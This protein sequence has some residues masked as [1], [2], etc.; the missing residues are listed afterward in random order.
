MRDLVGWISSVI[1]LVTLCKQIHKQWTL[2]TSE[3]VSKWF[4]V[5]QM[6]ANAGFIAYSALLDNKVFLITNSLLLL[7]SAIGLFIVF[8]HRQRKRPVGH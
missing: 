8:H 3:G 6:A 7:S 4:Y 1:L 2:E 5:G